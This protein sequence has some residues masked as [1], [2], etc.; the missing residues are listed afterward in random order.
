MPVTHDP[1]LD[2]TPQPDSPTADG[3]GT[4]AFF[5]LDKTI[6]SKSSTLVFGRSFYHGGL[7]NRRA[8]LRSSYA[9]FV[10]LLGGADHDQM[11]RLRTYLSQM[12]IGWP[13]AQ[14]RDIVHEAIDE[15][16]QPLIFQEA[17]ELIAS[18]HAAGREVVVVSSSGE[19][20]VEPI[21]AMVGADTVIATRMGQQDGRYTGEVEFYAYGANKAVA[22]RELAAQRGYDLGRCYAYSDSITDLPLLE[23]VGNPFAINPDRALRRIAS[24]RDWPILEFANPVRV[25]DRFSIGRLPSSKALA[26]LLGVGLSATAWVA[27]RRWSGL[28]Q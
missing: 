12:C 16:I 10:F 24:E 23:T 9:Q 6:I 18:H 3:A 17:A 11:E 7:I 26:A 1:T 14:V 25:S 19:E 4:A 15:L 8:V 27:R 28:R 13:V 20:I 2:T 21:G 5:D 22:V